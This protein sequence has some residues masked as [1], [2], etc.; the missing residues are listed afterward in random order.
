MTGLPAD[1]ERRKP[2]EQRNAA[3]ERRSGAAPEAEPQVLA[4]RRRRADAEHNRAA[5]IGAAIT[6][7]N[8]NPAASIED[9]AKT[10]GV[11]RQTVY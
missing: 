2:G 11:T 8:G 7:L 6:A 1:Q 3:E 5:I 10:A 9:V 4:R